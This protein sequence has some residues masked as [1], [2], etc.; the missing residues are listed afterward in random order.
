M[1]PSRRRTKEDRLDGIS[2]RLRE[3][4][5]EAWFIKLYTSKKKSTAGITWVK[6]LVLVIWE[7][8]RSIWKEQ[9]DHIHGTETTDISLKEIKALQS[10]TRDLHCKLEQDPFLITQ[11]L[12][13]QLDRP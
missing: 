1:F 10:M 4:R 2:T 7:Y 12:R 5:M 13:H 9:N 8:S 11:S 3:S 6:H